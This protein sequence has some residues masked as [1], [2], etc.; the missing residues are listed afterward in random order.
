MAVQNQT[1]KT[2]VVVEN[3][4]HDKVIIRM[5]GSR[6]NRMFVKQI[7]SPPDLP[8]MVDIPCSP[9]QK[10]GPS[11]VVGTVANEVSTTQCHDNTPRDVSNLAGTEQFQSGADDDSSQA[12]DMETYGQLQSPVPSGNMIQLLGDLP[13]LGNLM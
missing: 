9:V 3:Q 5:D 11:S 4:D 13:G 8:E 7:L 12:N 6:R 10:H 2:W 1:D